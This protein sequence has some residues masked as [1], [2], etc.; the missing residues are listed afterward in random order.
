MCLQR[1]KLTFEIT[2]C[3]KETIWHASSEPWALNAE[4][5]DKGTFVE[6][7]MPAAVVAVGF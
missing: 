5:G 6:I 4:N 7:L 3:G 1:W 2:Q